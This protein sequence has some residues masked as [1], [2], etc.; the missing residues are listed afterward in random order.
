MTFVHNELY[1]HDFSSPESF[2]GNYNHNENSYRFYTYEQFK[3]SSETSDHY[4]NSY[5]HSLSCDDS[6]GHFHY[7]NANASDNEFYA[8]DGSS[9]HESDANIKVKKIV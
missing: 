3:N 1:A 8:S 5:E 7:S 9:S 2:S 4:Y 6:N